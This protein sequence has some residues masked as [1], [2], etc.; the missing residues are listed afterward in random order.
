[1]HVVERLAVFRAWIERRHGIRCSRE[2]F[3]VGTKYPAEKI[4]G[5]A[6]VVRGL[7]GLTAAFKSPAPARKK[8]NRDAGCPVVFTDVAAAAG[9]KFIHERG[10]TPEHQLPETM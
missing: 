8:E 3:F 6:G 2:R 1:M 5:T 4:R 7:C 9:L 10:A